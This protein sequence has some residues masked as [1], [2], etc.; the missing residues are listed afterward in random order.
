MYDYKTERP[1][2]FTDE[3][4]RLFLK[5]RD[6][7]NEMLDY[8]VAVKMG[9]IVDGISGDNWEIMACIDRMVEL[10]EIKEMLPRMGSFVQDKI[11]M[12]A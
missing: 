2:L 10:G 5:V 12:R 1:K 7:V 4:Q 3:G 9:R 8:S 11:F 6:K